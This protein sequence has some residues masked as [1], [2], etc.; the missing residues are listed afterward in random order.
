[1]E[2]L[3]R[4]TRDCSDGRRSHKGERGVMVCWWRRKRERGRKARKTNKTE[5]LFPLQALFSL[6]RISVLW[7]VSVPP[8]RFRWV[9]SCSSPGRV[10]EAG[11][12]SENGRIESRNKGLQRWKTESQRRE[13][14]NGL[15]VEEK[16][17]ERE[18]G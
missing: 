11:T 17:R 1:M 13:R 18:K 8:V 10:R 4:G 5:D 6:R 15:L 3:N 9:S 2:E 7:R 12:L 16:E 14:S